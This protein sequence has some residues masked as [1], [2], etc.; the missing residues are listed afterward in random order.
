MPSILALSLLTRLTLQLRKPNSSTDYC[1]LLK[2]SCFLLWAWVAVGSSLLFLWHNTLEKN[3]SSEKWHLPILLLNLLLTCLRLFQFG[4]T[5]GRLYCSV[6]FKLQM[7]QTVYWSSYVKLS[8]LICWPSC[9]VSLYFPTSWPWWS[10]NKQGFLCLL[11]VVHYLHWEHFMWINSP[12]LV[13]PYSENKWHDAGDLLVISH[14]E[15]HC[16]PQSHQQQG[17]QLCIHILH[18]PSVQMEYRGWI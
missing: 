4:F 12:W 1:L 10:M 3:N 13:Y 17:M 7:I 5:C 18:I 8:A 9:E 6:F 14:P 16:T 15:C 2:T 11:N